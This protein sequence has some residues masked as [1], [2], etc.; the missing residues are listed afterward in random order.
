[1]F[2]QVKALFLFFVPQSALSAVKMSFF[3]SLLVPGMAKSEMLT[4]QAAS[5]KMAKMV[6]NA[7]ALHEGTMAGSSLHRSNKEPMSST[8]DA[9]GSTGVSGYGDALL[10]FHATVDD[11]ESYGGVIWCWK[12]MWKGTIWSEEGVWIHARLYAMNFAQLFI[13]I[14]FIILYV[15]FFKSSASLF[16]PSSE[17]NVTFSPTQTSFPSQTQTSFPTP[18]PSPLFFNEDIEVIIFLPLINDL[19]QQYL[20]NDFLVENFSETLWSKVGSGN[21]TEFVSSILNALPNDLLTFVIQ[22]LDTDTRQIISNALF[23]DGNNPE[24]SASPQLG[25]ITR[26]RMLEDSSNLTF[27]DDFSNFTFDDDFSSGSEGGLFDDLIPKKW[28]V[29]F[30]VTAGGVCAVAAVLSLFLIWIPSAVA[31]ILQFR[32]GVIGSLRDKDFV[33]YR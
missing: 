20:I 16:D 33:R 19:I 29:E 2:F 18:A 7:V 30:A 28:A 6:T 27:D 11:R 13:G 1:M 10:N 32:S 23:G 15:L 26:F 21:T 17:G 22:N 8:I 5:C 25:N 24:S 14:L 4:K 3:A 31:T 12:S 9:A